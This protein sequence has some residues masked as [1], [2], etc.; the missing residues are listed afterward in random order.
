MHCRTSSCPNIWPTDL[1][2]GNWMS[3][4]LKL[5]FWLIFV[6]NS[7]IPDSAHCRVNRAKGGR[8]HVAPIAT[9]LVLCLNTSQ[10]FHL[11]RAQY[12]HSGLFRHGNMMWLGQQAESPEVT[13]CCRWGS[14][15]K[16]EHR[17]K[18]SPCAKGLRVAVSVSWARFTCTDL[19]VNR[20]AACLSRILTPIFFGILSDN[21]QCWYN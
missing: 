15:M 9:H 13:G 2:T 19:S 8:S 4:A 12:L 1:H 14:E 16:D 18:L 11:P 21:R 17:C 10:I 5:I 6:L 3:D 7:G 20:A